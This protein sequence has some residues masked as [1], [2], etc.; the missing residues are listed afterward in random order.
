MY[1]YQEK[2]LNF[3]NRPVKTIDAIVSGNFRSEFW[4]QVVGKNSEFHLMLVDKNCE[5]RRLSVE[6]LK[7]SLI[8][9]GEKYFYA[10]FINVYQM[11]KNYEFCQ[12]V[13][14]KNCKL[15]QLIMEK[16]QE[17]CQLVIDKILKFCQSDMPKEEKKLK[18]ADFTNQSWEKVA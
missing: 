3:I 9:H 1:V 7:I 15:C 5:F 10:N 17:I 14:R 8:C 13:I 2:I 4:Q 12:L 16:Y 6:K 18:D 11:G